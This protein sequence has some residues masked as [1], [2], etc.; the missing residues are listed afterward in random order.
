MI[1]RRLE[2]TLSQIGDAIRKMRDFAEGMNFEDYQNDAED[3]IR[4]GA[5]CRDY[6]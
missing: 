3:E 4:D 5:L 1:D 2:L 6:F